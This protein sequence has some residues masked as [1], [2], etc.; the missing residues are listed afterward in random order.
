[1]FIFKKLITPFILPPGIF[2][3]ALVCAA[4]YL[5]RRNRAGAVICAVLAG[6][7]WVSSTKVF[8]DALLRPLEYKYSAPAAPAG[9]VI[10]VL[11]GGAYDS[12]EVYSAGERLQ[13]GSLERVSAAALLQKRTKL[14]VI[15]SGGAVFSN[16]AEAD[17]DGAYLEELGVPAKAIIKETQ[18]RDTYENAG[19][20]RRICEE[21]GYKKIIL[22]TSASHMPRAVYL[23]K[24]IG[25]TDIVP[26][27][28]TR[29][30]AKGAK[31][32]FRDYLPGTFYSAARALNE[33][34]GLLFYRLAR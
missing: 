3:A 4:V 19:F 13:P 6:G 8:S 23:Y 33:Y 32:S 20:T 15:V 7:M 5:R 26:F 29:T 34:L 17:A 14:P 1:M 22:L 16:I 11:G 10:V 12:Y 9:D 2:V 28:V 21:R 30:A 31:R 25:F 27:P 24:K 18:A